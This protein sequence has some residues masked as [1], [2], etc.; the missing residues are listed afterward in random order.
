MPPDD[1]AGIF[2]GQAAII[3]LVGALRCPSKAMNGPG[4]AV[5]WTWKFGGLPENR[6][7]KH[8]ILE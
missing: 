3:R 4:L 2:S 8:A 6:K 7:M 5:S 1:V